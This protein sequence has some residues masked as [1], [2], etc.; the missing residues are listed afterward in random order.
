MTR[1]NLSLAAL[2]LLLATASLCWNPVGML[3]LWQRSPEA[4]RAILIELRLP[5]AASWRWRLADRSG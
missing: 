1:L 5:R 3:T 2:A 4:A